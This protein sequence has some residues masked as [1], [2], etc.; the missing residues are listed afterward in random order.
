EVGHGGVWALCPP[1]LLF[2]PDADQDDQ[3]DAEP[4]VVLDGFTVAKNNYHNFANGLRWG[5]DGWLYGRCGHSCP[6]TLGLPGTPQAD[7]IPMDGGIWRYHPKRKVVEVLSHGTTNPWG[8]DWDQHGELFFINTVNGHLWHLQHG[9][10]FKEN[11]GQ[12]PN[13]Y[14]YDRLSH[15]A[16]HWHFDRSG[17]W[18][19]S[20]DG[21]ANDFGGGHSHI[22][23]LIYQGTDLPPSWQNKLFT[24]NQ[25][26]RRAN[27]ERLERV[28]SGYLG[29]HEP[30]V[31]L[32][33]DPWFRGLDL[34]QGPDGAL[35]ALD[36]C[37]TGE[38]HDH[39][40]VHRTSGRIYR[41][42]HGDTPASLPSDL[43]K[44]QNLSPTHLESLLRH[45]NVWYPRQ[46]RMLLTADHLPT[47]HRLAKEGDTPELRLRALWSLTYLDDA[48]ATQHL[49]D[50]LASENE[51]LRVW[52]IR[53]LLNPFPLDRLDSQRPAG[54]Q[55]TSVP[56][57]LTDLLKERAQ[58][59]GSA[60]VR[61]TIASGLQRLHPS[62][63]PPIA[64]ALAARSTDADDQNL[65]HL[66][67]Y[68]LLPLI[69]TDGDSL[70]P[71][72][73]ATAWPRLLQWTA[74]ALGG[75][76][77]TQPQLV[78]ALLDLAAQDPS[79]TPALLTGLTETYQGWRSAPKPTNWDSTSTTILEHHP[80][81]APNVETLATLFGEGMG[82][83][84]LRA[85]AQNGDADLASRSRALETLI[86]ANPPDLPA[87]CERLLRTRELNIVAVRGLAQIDDPTIG[88]TLAQNFQKWFRKNERRAVIEALCSRPTWAASL[89][90][91]IESGKI[92][93]DELTPYDARQILA[94][95]DQALQEKLTTA[96]GDLR[97][98][99][100]EMA[101]QMDAWRTYLTPQ[102][103][104]AADLSQGRVHY[105]TLCASCHQ[106]Y[107]QGGPLGPDLTGS[108]RS[109][110][111]YLL[112]A[113]ID[114]SAM[115]SAEYRMT[116]L[117]LEDGRLLSGVIAQETNKTVTLRLLTEETILEKSQ[118]TH[119]Q[120]APQ[121]IMP[122][123]LFQALD[124]ESTRDL[125]AYLMH[126]QQVSLP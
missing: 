109:E 57:T 67:W 115:V 36:W 16:D 12:S 43:A 9:S 59:D 85:L 68:G 116:T 51:H 107:G 53:L 50:F 28:G 56:T 124:Q 78:D 86:E 84:D 74:R 89:L 121:S 10:H 32:C 60:L 62:Q 37:D 27:C 83:D 7:R 48:E 118:I 66:V 69:E 1:R 23:M 98:S 82:L 92:P 96:W 73:Q 117:T 58:R 95:G 49:S 63:R 46:A 3:P 126:P 24:W 104:A 71:I 21:R 106:L 5:P 44:L 34:R 87:L 76:I 90:N 11:F 6:G 42:R 39:T 61:A 52:A 108:G 80:S 25:H 123:G 75:Q 15:H 47:L 88:T 22:G 112:E 122:A 111:D 102:V 77:E 64:Q 79:K 119:R 81:L 8:H 19:D 40:G 18:Q 70:L 110:L 97:Q 14:V 93:R 113:V 105:Q 120:L 91:A 13:P 29:R 20:R 17:R 45:P 125:I 65:S 55:N 26:G 38:C 35:Y 114:P 99:S 41:F 30:D 101:Q 33:R 2:F 31:L 4:Q 72:A 94:F 100:E 103:L 54:D